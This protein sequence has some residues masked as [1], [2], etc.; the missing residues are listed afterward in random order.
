MVQFSINQY[1]YTKAGIR[2]RK[3]FLVASQIDEIDAVGLNCGVG[4]GHMEQIMSDLLEDWDVMEKLKDKYI[5]SLP[6]AGYPERIR[7]H[8]T[9]AKHP[10]YFVSKLDE[11]VGQLIKHMQFYCVVK[12]MMK[13]ISSILKKK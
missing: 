1:G 8:I 3:L 10:D 6:N 13:S 5:V 2:A 12:K 11:L 9:F 7:N 4:P